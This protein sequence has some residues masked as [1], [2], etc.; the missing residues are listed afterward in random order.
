MDHGHP[1]EID[2]SL[3]TEARHP[4]RLVETARRS[5]R[6]DRDA[7]VRD[8]RV[9]DEKTVEGIPGL[10]TE[11]PLEAPEGFREEPRYERTVERV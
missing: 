7:R 2:Y 1:L 6:V 4:Q 11:A 9:R 3:V 10:M 8:A 5:A